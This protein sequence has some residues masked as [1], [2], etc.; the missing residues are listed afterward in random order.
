MLPIE[1]L[2]M[3]GPAHDR[4]TGWIAE[5]GPSQSQ[6]DG[7]AK[8]SHPVVHDVLL[9]VFARPSG[10]QSLRKHPPSRR[11]NFLRLLECTGFVNDPALR[12]ANLLHRH[13]ALAEGNLGSRLAVSD[14]LGERP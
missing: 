4:T 12:G 6:K 7:R 9:L 13:D 5:E 1:E 14:D 3:R 10:S 11:G 2:L 8:P